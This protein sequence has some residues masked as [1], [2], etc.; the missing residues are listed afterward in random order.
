MMNTLNKDDRQVDTV[1]ANTTRD[2]EE[3]LQSAAGEVETILHGVSGQ[4]GQTLKLSLSGKITPPDRMVQAA[5]DKMAGALQSAA[6][7][8][9]TVIQKAADDIETQLKTAGDQIE[10]VFRD[11]DKKNDAILHY[12][13]VRAEVK[14]NE[15]KEENKMLRKAVQAAEAEKV[16]GVG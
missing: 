13:E 7:E 4:A 14:I 1:F 2:V 8:V 15:L 11:A 3:A 6:G 12:A 5:T 9:D 16:A 10:H